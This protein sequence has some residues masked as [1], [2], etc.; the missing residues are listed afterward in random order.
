MLS[1]DSADGLLLL[2][3]SADDDVPAATFSPSYNGTQVTQRTYVNVA[4]V[5]VRSATQYSISVCG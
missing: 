1:L 2:L 5:D 4:I 3:S